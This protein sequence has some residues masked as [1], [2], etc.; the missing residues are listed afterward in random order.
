MQA[1]CEVWFMSEQA[2]PKLATPGAGLPKVEHVIARM[3]MRMRLWT[4]SRES[5]NAAFEA[6]R[7]KIRELYGSCDAERGA[8]RV[9]IK[10]L[11]GLEDSSRNWSVWMTLDHLR[12]T[13]H[14]MAYVI[15]ELGKDRQPRGEV[16]TAAVK[17]SIDATAA[18][19]EEF[20]ASCEA[21]LAAVAA[22][23]D[24][25]TRLRH[26]HPW[27]GAMDAFAWHALAGAHM[28]IHRR[29]LELIGESVI[30]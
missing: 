26:V 23:P 27:F 25:K 24:L 5:F 11:R 21:V 16:S 19:V 13:N 2:E 20:E 9:L 22:T 15:S 17:P 28:A 12:I 14:A 6:E 18:V 1:I 4:G 30:R 8:Q 3:L 7:E 29:Q 10:R